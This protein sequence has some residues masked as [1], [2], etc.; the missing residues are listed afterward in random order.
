MSD[1]REI[2]KYWPLIILAISIGF[3][4][5]LQILQCRNFVVDGPKNFKLLADISFDS[6]LQNFVLL[7]LL[8]FLRASY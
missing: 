7:S 6:G 2:W 4:S 5:I 3:C 8:I 1:I